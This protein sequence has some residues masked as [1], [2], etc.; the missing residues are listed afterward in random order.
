MLRSILHGTKKT[1]I[2]ELWKELS[3]HSREIDYGMPREMWRSEM[4]L[5]PSSQEGPVFW[6][7]MEMVVIPR[8][9]W[10]SEAYG[11]CQ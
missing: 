11:R 6:I 2:E 3:D 7:R 10:I 4:L 9:G 8:I 5:L 1:D